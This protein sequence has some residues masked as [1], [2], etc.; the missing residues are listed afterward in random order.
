MIRWHGIL[1]RWGAHIIIVIIIQIP[2]ASK[3]VRS[4]VF[5]GSSILLHVSTE[6]QLRA[7]SAMTLTY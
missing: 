1:E 6:S 4:F 7:N 3:V 5:M 2:P